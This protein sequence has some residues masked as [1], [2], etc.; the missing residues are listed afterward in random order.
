MFL[1]QI[2]RTDSNL[3]TTGYTFYKQRHVILRGVEIST[4][5]LRY[6]VAV[7]RIFTPCNDISLQTY[8]IRS[9]ELDTGETE[10]HERS[11]FGKRTKRFRQSSAAQLFKSSKSH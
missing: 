8:S 4:K 3:R 11:S 9:S 10:T 1:R 6:I 7:G 2:V 5:H